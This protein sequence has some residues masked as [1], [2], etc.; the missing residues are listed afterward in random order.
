MVEKYQTLPDDQGYADPCYHH[1]SQAE[2]AASKARAFNFKLETF[3]WVISPPPCLALLQKT[4]PSEAFA[5]Y[6]VNF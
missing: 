6:E 4:Q 1:S 5:K 3:A 2:A